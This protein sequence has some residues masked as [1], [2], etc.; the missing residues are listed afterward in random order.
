MTNVKHLSFIQNIQNPYLFNM[1]LAA[2][3]KYFFTES[4]KI[5]IGHCPLA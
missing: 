4:A 3:S 1:M 5:D 2:V